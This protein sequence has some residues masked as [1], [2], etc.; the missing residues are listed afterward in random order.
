MWY[1]LRKNDCNDKKLWN[2]NMKHVHKV[3]ETVRTFMI[4]KKFNS[5]C[6]FEI[7][8]LILDAN[9]ESIHTIYTHF[10][11]QIYSFLYYDHVEEQSAGGFPSR[12][13]YFL[14]TAPPNRSKYLWFQN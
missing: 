14:K 11:T 1:Y 8:G 6:F 5:L 13:R 3:N 7:V 9:Y 12:S 4:L 2:N 10:I